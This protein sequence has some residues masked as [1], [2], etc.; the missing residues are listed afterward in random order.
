MRKLKGEA[1]IKIQTYIIG[2]LV[3]F[4]LGHVIINSP[5]STVL[6]LG[7]DDIDVWEALCKFDCHSKSESTQVCVWSFYCGMSLWGIRLFQ[8]TI[9]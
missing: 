3:L 7:L 6:V 9:K 1:R 8:D 2:S 5:F 4:P